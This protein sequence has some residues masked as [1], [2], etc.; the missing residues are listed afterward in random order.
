MHKLFI[1]L[2]ATYF[3]LIE[4]VRVIFYYYP[5]LRFLWSDLLL[6][7][8]YLL[9]NPH[10]VSRDYLTQK[11]EL[12]VYKYGETPLTTLDQIARECS[13]LSKDVVYEL[14]CGSGR[15]AF[16]LHSFVRC[17]VVA[18]DF[19]PL[20]IQRGRWVN[21]WSHHG[22]IEFRNE[23]FLET[24]LKEATVIYLYGLCL[25]DKIIEQLIRRFE[26]LKAGTKIITVSYP[27]EDFSRPGFF[28]VTKQFL[29]TFP[30]GKAIV[31]LNVRCYCPCP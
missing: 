8:R 21:K 23:N 1:H 9:S 5:N 18:V 20:F 24:D 16:W 2:R 6:A 27:L 11:G 12:D 13:V 14:G 15:T 7:S 3:R 29:A 4:G 17:S 10:Q 30:W 31:Y 28:K 25:E 26:M 22:E 19:L